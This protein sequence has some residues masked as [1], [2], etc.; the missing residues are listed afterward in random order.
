VLGVYL[1]LKLVA[2]RQRDTADD[3]HR[4]ADPRYVNAHIAR[5]QNIVVPKAPAPH[6]SNPLCVKGQ[7]LRGRWARRRGDAAASLV[8]WF[9][10]RE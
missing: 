5:R 6:R 3:A 2:N 4:S 10:A 7:F 1:L 9:W 8:A